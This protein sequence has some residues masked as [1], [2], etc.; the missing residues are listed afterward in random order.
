MHSNM[1]CAANSLITLAN[2]HAV[3]SVGDLSGEY[4][5]PCS[6]QADALTYGLKDLSI[7]VFPPRKR[8]IIYKAYRLPKA[9]S[10]VLTADLFNNCLSY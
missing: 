2:H 4:G 9:A 5:Q 3:S 1:S 6:M 10:C 8:N 7:E